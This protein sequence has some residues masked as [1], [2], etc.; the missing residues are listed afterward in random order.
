MPYG[1]SPNKWDHVVT[2]GDSGGTA[3]EKQFDI[4]KRDQV[5]QIGLA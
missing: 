5:S 1:Q 2:T 4:V 3:V